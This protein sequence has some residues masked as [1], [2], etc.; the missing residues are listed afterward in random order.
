[1]SPGD[2][3]VLFGLALTIAGAMLQ[4]GFLWINIQGKVAAVRRVFFFIDL[5]S[6]DTMMVLQRCKRYATACVFLNMWTSPTPTAS[7]H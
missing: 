6:Q 2:F 1:M 3:S 4:G 7:R 5:D